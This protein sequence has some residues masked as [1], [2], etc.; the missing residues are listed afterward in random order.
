MSFVSN[1]SK[2]QK[3]DRTKTRRLHTSSHFRGSTTETASTPLVN[4]IYEPLDQSSGN[5]AAYITSGR[6]NSE[7]IPTAT[8]I[9][10]R[11]ADRML[12]TDS[13]SKEISHS[14]FHSKETNPL[15]VV[16]SLGG[17]ATALIE[18]RDRNLNPRMPDHMLQPQAE[19]TPPPGYDSDS[20]WIMVQ[21][22]CPKTPGSDE[23]A[24]GG[25]MEM[26]FD[27]NPTPSAHF[28]HIDFLFGHSMNSS[29]V[30]SF[31]FNPELDLDLET[32]MENFPIDHWHLPDP[33]VVPTDSSTMNHF[34]TEEVRLKLTGVGRGL[35]PDMITSCFY[36]HPHD[37]SP[38][39]SDFEVKPIGDTK[40]PIA[41]PPLSSKPYQ[42]GNRKRLP[43]TEGRDRQGDPYHTLKC[44]QSIRR[45]SA[46]WPLACPFHKKDPQ[47][48]RACGKYTL[49][50][51]KDVKQHIYRLHC[52]PE[53]YCSL[54]F[55][56]FKSSDERDC[57]TREG[58]CTKKAVP[59]ADGTISEDQKRKLKDCGSRGMSKQQQWMKLW[60]V[61]FPKVKHPGSPYAENDQAAML[62]R[63]RD[64]WGDNAREFI[65]RFLGDHDW[66]CLAPTHI[67]QI[68]GSFLD[69]IETTMIYSNTNADEKGVTV[70]QR[71]MAPGDSSEDMILVPWEQDSPL[72]TELIGS[73]TANSPD[74]HFLF[75]GD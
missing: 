63:I 26:D 37:L 75:Q 29:A 66:E 30:M 2:R 10:I 4:E 55:E 17:H 31:D 53:I 46:E 61:I 68:I 64:F 36:D 6:L 5:Q 20:V 43:A 69:Y 54:C 59:I 32:T 3:R 48:Y 70:L 60:E 56:K 16:Y 40:Q 13:R 25:G 58:R 21:H 23:E 67:S 39:T 41:L 24:M 12:E 62:S 51:I 65:T 73:T 42:K 71:P 28:P 57:H 7:C 27:L 52:R 15:G 22:E 38:A 9:Q 18:D 34:N 72:E 47:R 14:D 11:S 1:G 35:G 50:R 74:T 33:P 45:V 19:S 49:R 8:A 44:G